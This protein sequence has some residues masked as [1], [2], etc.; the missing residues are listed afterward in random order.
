MTEGD[1]V[2]RDPWDP[3]PR[4]ATAGGR[5]SAPFAFGM[6]VFWIAVV[7]SGAISWSFRS[8]LGGNTYYM[9]ML[10]Y[11]PYFMTFRLN[12]IGTLT[13]RPQFWPWVLTA[14]VPVVLFLLGD[15]DPWAAESMKVRIITFSFVAGSALLLVAPDAKRMLR[16]A[17]MIALGI[18]IP[19][20]FIELIFGSIFSVTEGRAAGLYGNANDAGAAILLSLLF[21]ID[22]RRPT[23]GGLMLAAISAAAVFSTFSRSGIL[24]AAGLFGLYAFLP[25]SGPAR[26]GGAQ[27]MLALS[28]IAVFAVISIVWMSQ[29]LDLSDEAAMRLNSI[30][31]GNVNDASAQGRVLLAQHALEVARENFWG[32]G[33]GFVERKDVEPHNTYL[34]LAIDYGIPGVLLY[35]TIL[36][37]ALGSALRAGW[38]RA[39]NAILIALLL[40]WSSFFTHYVAN[41]SFFAIAFASFISGSLVEPRE[42]AAA[43]GSASVDEPAGFPALP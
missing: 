2:H 12:Q 43:G 31:T 33:L 10:L 30:L 41:A 25:R 18:T 17:A 42:R 38:R 13:A 35:L 15:G 32:H 11:L 39:S 19:I 21:V 14:V 23:P 40:I 5:N 34:Y 4:A 29:N 26:D 16:T 8:T 28:A 1:F 20:C 9:M 3:P 27:R 24:F 36:F 6:G 37:G 22:L 7:M